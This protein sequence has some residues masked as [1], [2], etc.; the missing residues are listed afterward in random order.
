MELQ[1]VILDSEWAKRKDGLQYEVWNEAT[2]VRRLIPAKA[3][4][5]P[6]FEESTIGTRPSPTPID[7]AT[8]IVRIYF[9][10]TPS[11]MAPAIAAPVTYDI[12]GSR[13]V[14]TDR[15]KITPRSDCMIVPMNMPKDVPYC[16]LIRIRTYQKIVCRQHL[17][18]DRPDE[19]S[20]AR[21][22]RVADVAVTLGMAQEVSLLPMHI[23]SDGW[24]Y[25]ADKIQDW[26]PHQLC[27]V[28]LGNSLASPASPASLPNE[29]QEV[30]RAL[31]SIYTNLILKERTMIRSLSWQESIQ[32]LENCM[33]KA[34]A[35][36]GYR[37]PG[38]PLPK[39]ALSANTDPRFVEDAGWSAQSLWYWSPD[40]DA[41][42]AATPEWYEARMREVL[43]V[44]AISVDT[45]IETVQRMA[46][47]STETKDWEPIEH[48]CLTSFI[49][50]IRMHCTTRQYI[51]DHQIV[52]GK[53]IDTDEP[54]CGLH[55][56]G[57]CEDGSSAVYQLYM[58]LLFYPFV[59]VDRYPLVKAMRTCAAIVG[60]PCGI[61]GTGMDPTVRGGNATEVA[62]MFGMAIPFPMFMRA[63]TGSYTPDHQQLYFKIFGV[64]LPLS[65]GTKKYGQVAV[66][67]SI[68]FSTP[69]YFYHHSADAKKMAAYDVVTNWLGE[70]QDH[71][72]D[73]RHYTTT[74]VLEEGRKGH[75]HAMRCFTDVIGVLFPG[76]LV[77]IKFAGTK[78]RVMEKKVCRS[79]LF[80]YKGRYGI[81]TRA[82]FEDVS[83]T[84]EL[85]AVVDIDPSVVE[86]EKRMMR[87]YDR[88]LVPLVHDAIDCF[89]DDPGW[90]DRILRK[91]G[92]EDV[93]IPMNHEQRITVFAYD[94]TLERFT[95]DM[96]RLRGEMESGV[97]GG[98]SSGAARRGV[99]RKKR[100][101]GMAVHKF[102]WCVA[103][104]FVLG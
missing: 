59:G 97:Y 10:S 2:R 34:E 51:P 64:R 81:A 72:I 96:E 61:A 49:R 54:T 80:D 62:H 43:A 15:G 14:G 38:L 90:M 85:H 70:T 30:A 21:Y 77:G 82:L 95:E 86:I 84:F 47:G 101:V 83:P 104:T 40:S 66:L 48:D 67:E 53:W 16:P 31:S 20:A 45:F 74:H 63:V 27:R 5:E 17:N 46:Q 79:F 44:R 58:T 60:V 102:G 94:V 28:S 35:P 22:T 37:V 42:P 91:Y 12:R 100:N 52:N 65:V 73:W 88:P 99:G 78:E 71:E 41:G 87:A 98:S 56:P 69:Y 36:I 93:Q 8:L 13:M 7:R 39:W 76:G 9:V 23:A 1:C 33:G 29:L 92:K 3:R 25:S 18:N 19:T 75:G 11:A 4:M 103:V 55:S 57:D 6:A 68:I 50:M 26:I 24:A 32:K 89:V